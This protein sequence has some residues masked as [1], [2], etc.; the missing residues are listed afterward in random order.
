MNNHTLGYAALCIAG[1][2]L[3]GLIIYW[4]S[5]L[6]EKGVSLK[7]PAKKSASEDAKPGDGLPVEYHI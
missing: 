7:P 5:N 6:I 3:W 4:I 1:P 2:V